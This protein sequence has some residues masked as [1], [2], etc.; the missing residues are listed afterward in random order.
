MIHTAKKLQWKHMVLYAFSFIAFLMLVWSIWLTSVSSKPD[1]MHLKSI[2]QH[3]EL[4]LAEIGED[5]VLEVKEFSDDPDAAHEKRIEQETILSEHKPLQEEGA[6][7]EEKAAAEDAPVQ[8]LAEQ[9]HEEHRPTHNNQP[10]V[11]YDYTKPMIAVV[12]TDLGLQES[13]SN[14]V[15]NIHKP[16]SYGISPY[17]THYRRLI[18]YALKQ[19]HEMYVS[20]PFHPANYPVDNAGVMALLSHL[21]PD[22][23][24]NRIDWL[25][26]RVEPIQGVYSSG[27]EQFTNDSDRFQLFANAISKHKLLWLHVNYDKKSPLRKAEIAAHTPLVQGDIF[28]DEALTPERLEK[29]FSEAKKKAQENGHMVLMLKPFPLSIQM[30]EKQIAVWEGEGV[31]LVPLSV[32]QQKRQKQ[33]EGGH[34]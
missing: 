11:N 12:V 10:S 32:I 2:G 28:L 7:S 15:L 13:V 8:K 22:A 25:L 23:V 29:Q 9:A 27:D 30:L 34:G 21:K 31:Q 6:P 5:G 18:D 20:V 4:A 16:I 17:G 33:Q 26:S 19:G 24:Q 14:Q 3:V 1:Y